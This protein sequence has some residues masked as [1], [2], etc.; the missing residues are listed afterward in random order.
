MRVPMKVAFLFP[1]ITVA[2]L[3]GGF[4]R[5]DV[6]LA[7]AGSGAVRCLDSDGVG[8]RGA[9]LSP[10]CQY[11]GH[12]RMQHRRLHFFYHDLMLAGCIASTR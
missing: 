7:L 2:R 3:N 6:L 1:M 5:G 8:Q 10:K 4:G 11:S 9:A 12:L